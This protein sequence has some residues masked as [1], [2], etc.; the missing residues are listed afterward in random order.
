MFFELDNNFKTLQD[1]KEKYITFNQPIFNSTEEVNTELQS[2]IKIYKASDQ[3]IFK[4]FT[5]FLNK[6]QSEIINSFTTIEISHK[7]NREQKTFCSHLS[8]GPMEDLIESQ[9]TLKE[10]HEAFLIFIIHVIV[11]FGLQEKNSYTCRT[12]I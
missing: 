11:F 4:D 6:Y 7:T 8:N 9:K 10:T 1:L 5:E 12:K 3:P 2:L